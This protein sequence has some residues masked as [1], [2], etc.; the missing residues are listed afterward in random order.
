MREVAQKA[1]EDLK[2]PRGG[3]VEIVKVKGDPTVTNDDITKLYEQLRG[4]TPNA[5]MC[6]ANHVDSMHSPCAA[7]AF[8][9]TASSPRARLLCLP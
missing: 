6:V 2:V 1:M 3:S 8:Q 5:S 4:L 7:A 9:P